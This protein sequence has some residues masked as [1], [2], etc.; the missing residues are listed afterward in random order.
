MDYSKFFDS[1]AEFQAFMKECFEEDQISQEAIVEDE[2]Y[3]A[4][5]E[6][7]HELR[8]SKETIAAFR[9]F[10]FITG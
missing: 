9:E 7:D 6:H 5:L 4:W 3:L 8:M 2:A 1:G 10:G